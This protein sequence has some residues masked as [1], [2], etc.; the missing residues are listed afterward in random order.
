MD[1]FSGMAD[2]CKNFAE[3][4]TVCRKYRRHCVYIFH[5]IVPESQI[6][7]KNL[8]QTSIFNIFPSS[9]PYNN[10]A[11]ILQSNCRQTTRKY[12]PALSMW[13]NRIFTDLAITDKWHCL[14][15]DSSGVNKNDPSRYRTQ[16]NDPDKQVGYFNQPRDDELYNVF[17]SNRIKAE[18]FSSGIYFKIERV[19]G[20]DKTFD[21]QKTLKQ[22]DTSNRFSTFNA[23]P[24]S[25]AEFTGRGRKKRHEETSEYSDRRVR[26]S[27]KL[28]SG[29]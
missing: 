23:D 3:V 8:S 20:K 9:V 6:W 19:Q 15:I 11:K 4:L 18:N 25:S 14:T 10:V 2:S 7:K 28:L 1:K 26:K 24:E 22:H 16:G 21:A 27:P 17:I 5:I 29:R 13:L 12:V